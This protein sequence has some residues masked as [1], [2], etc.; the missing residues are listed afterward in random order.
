MHHVRKGHGASSK[1]DAAGLVALVVSLLRRRRQVPSEDSSS[2]YFA[3]HVTEC[4]AVAATVVED[5]VN[6]PWVD[7]RRFGDFVEARDGGS[8]ACCGHAIAVAA[9]PAARRFGDVADGIMCARRP[10]APRAAW[11]RRR[12]RAG[13]RVSL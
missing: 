13:R 6:D 1:V 2:R 5:G 10:R 4:C 9:A 3:R 12:G 8:G 11:P 7:A